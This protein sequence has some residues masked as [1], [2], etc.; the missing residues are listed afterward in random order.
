VAAGGAV[1]LAALIPMAAEP[2]ALAVLGLLA[3]AMP[4]MI[5]SE[6]VC[7]ELRKRI[8]HEFVGP[9]RTAST[10]EWTPLASTAARRRAPRFH[11]HRD[12]REPRLLCPIHS[13][14]TT[15]Q[16]LPGENSASSA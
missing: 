11:R 9:R 7:A 6:A 2:P 8:R 12:R 4:W 15:H 3:A 13:S 14:R 16:H 10:N 1:V 5:A